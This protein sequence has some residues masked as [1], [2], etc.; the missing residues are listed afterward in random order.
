MTFSFQ[1]MQ[2]FQ[3]SGLFE[4]KA[5]QLRRDA[6]QLQTAALCGVA[7]TGFLDLMEGFYG[8]DET[9]EEQALG[10]TSSFAE[11][12]STFRKE[13]EKEQASVSLSKTKSEVEGEED[14]RESDD[15]DEDADEGSQKPL[16]LKQKKKS[17][18]KKY[19]SYC[20]IAEA[21]LFYPTSSKTVH[22]TGVDN[23]YIGARENLPQ[24]RGL[25]CC[26]YGDC[27]YGAQV[28]GATLSHIRRVH[29]GHA[30]A[31]KYCPQKAWW[32]A[33]YWLIHMSEEHP[34]LPIYEIVNLPPNLEAVKVEPDIFVSEER[35]EVPVPKEV[36]T[37]KPPTK[38]PRTS[39]LMSYEEWEQASKE[40]KLFLL[41]DSPN[42]NQPRPQAAA[43]RYRYSAADSTIE[44]KK[45]DNAP[46]YSVA[47][48]SQAATVMSQHEGEEFESTE[49]YQIES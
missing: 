9:P 6:L 33:R 49:T 18:T 46:T 20:S 39:P 11:F 43:I 19:P 48:D 15:S 12:V 1:A 47:S 45:E 30:I 44:E 40:G 2:L 29:L 28:R 22:E 31:C 8:V 38:K 34:D 41:A 26:L 42:P 3:Y 27:D 17:G 25:Y 23:K 35:F 32:Q 7:S 5:Q 37:V 10:D 13:K 21:T 36:D 16:T 24:Y 4:E 14:R